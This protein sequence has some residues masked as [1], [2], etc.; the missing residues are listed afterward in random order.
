MI[1]FEQR[2][3]S[4]E[5]RNKRVEA[6]KAWETSWVRRIA[7]FILTYFVILI[8]GLINKLS[9]PYVTSVVPAMGFVLSTLTLSFFKKFWI[10]KYGKF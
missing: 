9:N 3:K 5:E 4:I 8:F 1:N 2:I 6:D 10:K 7:L